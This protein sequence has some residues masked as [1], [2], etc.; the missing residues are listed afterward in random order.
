MLLYTAQCFGWFLGEFAFVMPTGRRGERSGW[1]SG[2]RH[3][4]FK[5][6]AAYISDW[7]NML[8]NVCCGNGTTG[9]V[10]DAQ[11][12]AKQGIIFLDR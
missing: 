9:N 4:L 3:A 1:R 7:K 5:V 12:T 11:G 10:F 8:S 6:C 2:F